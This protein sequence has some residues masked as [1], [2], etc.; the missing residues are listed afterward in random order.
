MAWPD[1]SNGVNCYGFP[2]KF[3]PV[4]RKAIEEKMVTWGR[5]SMFAEACC[6]PFEWAGCKWELHED[7]EVVCMIFLKEGTL[8]SEDLTA[9]MLRG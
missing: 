6:A 7:S 8:N 2:K 3:L 4:I 9:A 5:A 1:N